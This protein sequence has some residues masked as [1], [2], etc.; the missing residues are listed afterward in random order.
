MW[1]RYSSNAKS[2]AAHL[3]LDCPW[4]ITIK[5][6][7]KIGI[8]SATRCAPIPQTSHSNNTITHY[9]WES[10]QCQSEAFSDSR[11]LWPSTLC[12]T[13]HPTIL[14][15][16]HRRAQ[17][18][19]WIRF[20]LKSVLS[21]REAHSWVCCHSKTNKQS[22]G[23]GVARHNTVINTLIVAIIVSLQCPLKQKLEALRNFQLRWMNIR[24]TPTLEIRKEAEIR[25]R[26]RKYVYCTVIK[27]IFS[28]LL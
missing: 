1:I 19:R 17:K 26:K 6:I 23:S 7:I 16:R 11:R 27:L 10:D 20:L 3:N 15:T 8:S 22:Y 9:H 13:P 21:D 2:A 25:H 12:S 28:M 18:G 5:L 4:N 14:S 24:V